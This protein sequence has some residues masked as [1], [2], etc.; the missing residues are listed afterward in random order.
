VETSTSDDTL[1]ADAADHYPR[2]PIRTLALFV[3]DTAVAVVVRHAVTDTVAGRYLPGEIR[4]LR[5]SNLSPIDTSGGGS[6]PAH[7]YPY[8]KSWGHGEFIDYHAKTNV[9]TLT[10]GPFVASYTNVMRVDRY[11]QVVDGDDPPLYPTRGY[12]TGLHTAR[13]FAPLPDTIGN[14]WELGFDWQ[15][16]QFAEPVFAWE[17]NSGYLLVQTARS[18][19]RGRD[20][21]WRV[22]AIDTAGSLHWANTLASDPGAIAVVIDSAEWI[23]TRLRKLYHYPSGHQIV[24]QSEDL[25]EPQFQRLIGDRFLRHGRI[26]G[27]YRLELYS[28][29][30]TPIASLDLDRT[31][32]QH[33]TFGTSD[34][35]IAVLSAS[36]P[37][38]EVR[39]FNQNLENANPPILSIDLPEMGTISRVRGAIVDRVLYIAWAG[40]DREDGREEAYVTRIGMPVVPS[41]T[42]GS[43]QVEGDTLMLSDTT[44]IPD[45]TNPDLQTIDQF[46][47][48]PLISRYGETVSLS[49][50]PNPTTGSV[51]MPLRLTLPLK[52]MM[53]ISDELGRVVAVREFD[54]RVGENR[55][56]F[57]LSEFEIGTYLIRLQAGNARGFGK[58]QFIGRN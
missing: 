49:L 24:L 18:V 38:I 21:V 54:G 14:D 16:G 44:L 46:S 55:L 4:Y 41:T 29:D 10:R 9:A 52:I 50:Y 19:G 5:K 53:S 35:S 47:N 1:V 39:V 36:G 37:R 7:L 13:G 33:V 23:V 30:A 17:P 3:R 43:G 56:D 31:E 6:L 22:G 12:Y 11:E 27:G 2:I 8:S 57:D 51:A 40:T 26:A 34:N 48:V 15:I 42:T 25:E 45:G 32:V 20:W 58:V 28:L